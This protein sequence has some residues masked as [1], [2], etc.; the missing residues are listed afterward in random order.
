MNY[1]VKQS[2]VWVADV[3]E[4]I[5]FTQNQKDYSYTILTSEAASYYFTKSIMTTP[6]YT[7]IV[8]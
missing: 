3:A 6:Y 1:D 5:K 7:I 2:F 4:R 8:S